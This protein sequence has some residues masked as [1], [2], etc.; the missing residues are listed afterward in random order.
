MSWLAA[1][2]RAAAASARG[3][4]TVQSSEWRARYRKIPTRDAV[5]CRRDL[6]YD[7]VECG[8]P[9][10]VH[11]RPP[12]TPSASEL[13]QRIFGYSQ[14]RG[15]QQAIIEHVAGGGDALVLMPT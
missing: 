7:V 14:F 2:C 5:P 13:L 10:P 12:M 8:M 15:E 11:L 9:A 3:G 6:R 1:A 4:R